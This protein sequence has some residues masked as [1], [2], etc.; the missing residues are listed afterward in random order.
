MTKH[1]DVVAKNKIDT[2]IA[3]TEQLVRKLVNAPTDIKSSD[4]LGGKKTLSQPGK[5]DDPL[6]ERLE[7]SLEN[8]DNLL[9]GLKKGSKE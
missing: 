8:L 7:E 5:E 9:E 2:S 4:N 6:E 3:T 1:N